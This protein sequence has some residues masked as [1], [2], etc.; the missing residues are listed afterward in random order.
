MLWQAYITAKALP[1]TCWMEVIDW[2]KYATTTLDKNKEAF[3]V[4]VTF[5]FSFNDY[6]KVQLV[7]LFTNDVFITMLSEYFKFADVFFAKCAI[8]FLKFTGINDYTI[9]L[10]ENQQL[11]YKPVYNLE[12]IELEMQ[13][14]YIKINWANS[15]ICPFKSLTCVPILFV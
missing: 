8:E 2:K 1:I 6:H 9:D 13:K 12:P 4:H 15:F 3:V 7:L 11:F 14:T 10:I 5:F